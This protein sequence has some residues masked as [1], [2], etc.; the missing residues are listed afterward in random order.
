MSIDNMSQEKIDEYFRKTIVG[1]VKD[2]EKLKNQ[3]RPEAMLWSTKL[4]TETS[5]CHT[6]YKEIYYLIANYLYPHQGLGIDI[7][8]TGLTKPT[9]EATE[10]DSPLRLY[11]AW[12]KLTGVLP[13]E[14]DI[15]KLLNPTKGYSGVWSGQELGFNVN[16]LQ[17]IMRNL[18]FVVA[19][20]NEAAD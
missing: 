13:S 7:T 20:I 6:I 19:L 18:R 3:V 14:E 15:P 12:D 5:Y 4:A 8:K 11:A 2:I 10:L 16:Y 9:E 1:L 17:D